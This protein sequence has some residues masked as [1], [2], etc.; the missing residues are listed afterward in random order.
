[1][2]TLSKQCIKKSAALILAL[3]GLGTYGQAA[4]ANTQWEDYKAQMVNSYY[5]SDYRNIDKSVRYSKDIKTDTDGKQYIH[6]TV[7][8]NPTRERWNYLRAVMFLPKEAKP[9]TIKMGAWY[10]NY[11]NNTWKGNY[12]HNAV[13]DHKTEDLLKQ[14]FFSST[15]GSDYYAV[16]YHDKRSEFENLWSN[17]IQQTQEGNS[18]SNFNA[19]KDEGRFE[20]AFVQYAKRIIADTVI[21]RWEFDTPITSNMD[22]DNIPFIVGVIGEANKYP[23]FLGEMERK[24]VNLEI[25]DTA[26]YQFK[27]PSDNFVWV[28]RWGGITTQVKEQI[29][30]KVQVANGYVPL[31]LFGIQE[32]GTNDPVIVMPEAVSSDR[33]TGQTL[34]ETEPSLKD[35]IQHYNQPQYWSGYGRNHGYSYGYGRGYGRR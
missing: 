26:H 32:N 28:K 7:N 31:D 19:I 10:Q 22:I 1:M 35:K 2:L 16:S 13:Y 23:R 21:Y 5:D 9:T 11:Q 24:K 33:N 34:P 27:D 20:L 17:T 6:W 29:L 30:N 8:F 12:Y 4:Q 18:L 25:K 14:P 3:V 15:L